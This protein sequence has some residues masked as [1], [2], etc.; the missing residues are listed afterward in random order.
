MQERRFASNKSKESDGLGKE[1]PQR[2]KGAWKPATFPRRALGGRTLIC[3]LSLQKN[4]ASLALV[5]KET[6]SKEHSALGHDSVC[7][8]VSPCF[9]IFLWIVYEYLYI[10]V[11][12]LESASGVP[13]ASPCFSLRPLAGVLCV[14]RSP[15][16][17]GGLQSLAINIPR[18]R[19]K[20]REKEEQTKR[21]DTYPTCVEFTNK[22]CPHCAFHI[23]FENSL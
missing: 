23:S 2:T 4:E 20:S 13:A 19:Y 18:K 5:S 9:N 14:F 16:R 17:L 3:Y 22:I 10:G 7:I 6:R 1:A 12:P 21:C 11:G 8:D 15:E